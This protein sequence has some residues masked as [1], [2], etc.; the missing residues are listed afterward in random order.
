[1]SDDPEFPD[2]RE[3]FEAGDKGALLEVISICAESKWRIPPWA[4][5]AFSEIC[6]RAWSGEVKSWDDVFGVPW[7]DDKRQQRAIRTESKAPHVWVRIKK[8]RGE[9]AS[10]TNELFDRVGAEFGLSRSV[11]SRL[12]YELEEVVN[13]PRP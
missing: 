7:G 3:R 9:G 13:R 4:S 5:L 10:I 11:V 2:D 1:M 12:Y 6:Q 8:L